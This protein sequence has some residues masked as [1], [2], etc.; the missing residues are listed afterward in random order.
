MA[1]TA[2][3]EDWNSIIPYKIKA[4]DLEHPTESFVFRCIISFLKMLK[5]NVTEFE[6]MYNEP[7]EGLMLKRKQL[8][9]HINHSYQLCLG[10][11][12][13]SFFY[14]DLIKPSPKKTIH[15]L[16]ILLN[17]LFYVNMVR[18]ETVERATRCTEKYQELS[19]KLNQQQR[20]METHKIKVHNIEENI[21]E[22][23]KQL[24]QLQ[25]ENKA[26]RT[27]KTQLKERMATIKTAKSEFA[28]KISKLKTKYAKI[29]EQRVE[30]KEA[31]AL[32]EKNKALETE[33]AECE[34][35]EKDLQLTNSQYSTLIS[36]IKPCLHIAEEILQ[37]PI[38][39][40]LRVL[41]NQVDELRLKHSKLEQ[42]QAKK[43]AMWD[44]L[45]INC[46]SVRAYMDEKSKELAARQKALRKNER[47]T[48]SKFKTR[49]SELDEL[50]EKNGVYLDQIEILK[51]E[52]L[53]VMQ[54]ADETMAFLMRDPIRI[55][56]DLPRD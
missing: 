40:S 7:K 37:N 31:A 25:N 27:K 32:I 56:N 4:A 55:S 42:D 34:K 16:N 51:E 29:K 47:Q 28:G 45:K 13:S 5:Y 33:I 18:D 38:D 23:N 35:Q 21:M 14:V 1:N 11:K 2:F 10:S 48:I 52:I 39:N 54:I 50:Q 24:P 8:A 12:S 53:L 22:M 6:N 46:E 36:R 9:A 43:V 20:E 41:E 26:L 15:V 17:Y 3:V 19:A 44:A 30:D 49:Q